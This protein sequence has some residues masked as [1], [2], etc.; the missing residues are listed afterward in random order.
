[1]NALPDLLFT[2]N[3][4]VCAIAIVLAGVTAGYV[5]RTN[6]DDDHV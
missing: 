5:L 3:V 4:A 2:V 6:K 1:M